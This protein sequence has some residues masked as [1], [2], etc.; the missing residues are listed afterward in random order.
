MDILR[1]LQVFDGINFLL[2]AQEKFVL[3]NLKCSSKTGILFTSPFIS[4]SFYD[5]YDI[6]YQR[7]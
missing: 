3:G 1:H 4:L 7:S 5:S 6:F 2:D